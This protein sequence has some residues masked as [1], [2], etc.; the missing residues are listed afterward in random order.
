MDGQTDVGTGRQMGGWSGGQSDLPPGGQMDGEM[1]GQTDGYG[2]ADIRA[3][4]SC[5]NRQTDRQTDGW[6]DSLVGG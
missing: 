4:N 3:L 5:T 1:E 6:V 2:W